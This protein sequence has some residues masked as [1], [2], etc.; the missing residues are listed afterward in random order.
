M[1]HENDDAAARPTPSRLSMN[2]SAGAR[3]NGLRW[4]LREATAGLHDQAD[5]LGG[6]YDLRSRAGYAAFLSAHARALPGLEAAVA[7]ALP[8]G[9]MP[10]WPRRRRAASLLTDL[11]RLEL[12]VPH[13]L[14]VA[15]LGSAAAAWGM[16]YVLEGSRLG[17]AMLLKAVRTSP[18]LAE[19]GADAY[20]SHRPDSEG[21]P[22]FVARLEQALPDPAFW[23]QA[24]QGA[25]A[26]FH[27]FLDALRSGRAPISDRA[28]Y[29]TH[30]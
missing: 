27:V 16:A 10:D 15:P 25:R 19:A 14:P 17:N 21:W 5:A 1:R 22:G 12:P 18:T 26:A 2:Q 6:A 3:S 28:E 4:H 8:P 11:A 24:G 20:L 30:E 9:A 29:A 13:A 23:P 7:E